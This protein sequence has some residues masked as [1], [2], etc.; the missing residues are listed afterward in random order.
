MKNILEWKP[1]KYV[2]VRG[3]LR[4]TRDRHELA[5]GSRLIADLVADAYAQAFGVHASGRLLDMGCGKVPFYAAYRAFVSNVECIDWSHSPH[6]TDFVD[7]TCDLAGS[8]PYSDGSFDTILL[9]D[10]LEHL[11][12]PI[13]CWREM[14]RLLSPGGKVLLN[15]PF[16]YQIHEEPHDFYRYTEFALRRFAHSTGFEIIELRP[17]GGALEIFADLS[18]KLLA[19]AK[20]TSLAASVQAAV[21]AFGRRRL[22]IKVMRRTSARFPLGY[23]MVAEKGKA[24]NSR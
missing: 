11:P 18:A 20:L 2:Q 17:I 6:G 4:G 9:S 12:E 15:V 1:S 14:N 8:I 10:V 5:I 7:K 21:L 23:F 24:L 19:G 13:N 22:G 3:R 16:Y